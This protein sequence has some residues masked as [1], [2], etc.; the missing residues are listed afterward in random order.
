[1]HCWWRE[2]SLTPALR[3]IAPKSSITAFYAGWPPHAVGMLLSS[4]ATTIHRPFSMLPRSCSKHLDVHVVGSITESPEDE[5]LVLRNEQ[6]TPEL[7]VCAVPYLRDRDIR[8]AEAGESVEDK[9][10]N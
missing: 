4:R 1:M 7:I 8:V 2:M 9:E 5:V 6:D 10:R 3:A